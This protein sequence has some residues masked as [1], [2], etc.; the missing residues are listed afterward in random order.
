LDGGV[1]WTTWAQAAYDGAFNSGSNINLFYQNPYINN[2]ISAQLYYPAASYDLA[3]LKTIVEQRGGDL[4][5][6]SALTLSE[7]TGSVVAHHDGTSGDLTQTV[8]DG[9]IQGTPEP[10]VGLALTAISTSVTVEFYNPADVD[11]IDHMEVWVS[12]DGLNFTQLGLDVA[13]VAGGAVYSIADPTIYASGEITYRVETFN[14][15][16]TFTS[17]TDTIT[18]TFAIP[19]PV[20]SLALS[21]VAGSVT[22]AFNNPIDEGY[23]DHIEIWKTSA[24]IPLVQ[25]GSD[26]PLVTGA[27]VYSVG[28]PTVYPAN[29]V[30]TY[31]VE[32]HNVEGSHSSN[33]SSISISGQATPDPARDL[34]LVQS[35][36]LITIEFYN[37]INEA[38]INH[39]EI[40]RGINNAGYSQL[41]ADI[42]IVP[43]AAVYSLTDTGNYNAGDVIWYHIQGKS[44]VD[45]VDDEFS[46]VI[47]TITITSTT[48]DAPTNLTLTEGVV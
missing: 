37:P 14:I 26:I 31:Y 19:D 32:T 4:T 6:P 22:I 3:E 27:A 44:V 9:L 45:G 17:V 15:E 33:S 36:T 29:D 16:G 34:T 25:L 12:T 35:D 24:G 11:H 10:V 2:L 39:Y 7:A 40:W 18:V 23:I 46:T 20:T 47:G 21:E 30:I 48:P 38:L 1:T 43:G 8:S 28:D 42:P 41:G 5:L 13:Y